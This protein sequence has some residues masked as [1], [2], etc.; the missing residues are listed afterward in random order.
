VLEID[1]YS[2]AGFGGGFDR[3]IRLCILAQRLDNQLTELARHWPFHSLRKA[4]SI[5]GNDNGVMRF[6]PMQAPESYGAGSPTCK[7]VFEC[8]RQ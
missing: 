5:V 2:R 1:C 4:D 8:I 7:R 6:T 3:Q